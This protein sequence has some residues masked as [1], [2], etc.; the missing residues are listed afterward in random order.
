MNVRNGF[1]YRSLLAACTAIFVLV[2]GESAM[3]VKVGDITR[4]KGS[5]RN[6]LVGF[7]LVTG[8]GKN[9]DKEYGPTTRALAKL[10]ERFASPVAGLEELE[11]AGV[12]IVSLTARLPEFGVREGDTVDV[13]VTAVGSAKSLQG[14]RLLITP[15]VSPH[16][17]DAPPFGFAEGIVRC[18]DSQSP[19]VGVVKNGGVMEQDVIHSFI[20]SGRELPYKLS[21]I[22][23]TENYLTLLISDPQASAVLA[24]TIAMTVNGMTRNPSQRSAADDDPLS[25]RDDLAMA[26][27]PRTVLVRVP[28][29][30]MLNPMG[31]VDDLLQ[32][33]VVEEGTGEARVTLNRT[34]GTIVISGDVEISPVA[35][36][37]KGISIVPSANGTAAT[38]PA[39]PVVAL[40]PT[41]GKNTKLAEL[42]DNLNKLQVSTEVLIDIIEEIHKT[43]NLHGKLIRETD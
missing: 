27:D 11:K 15:M 25:I 22:K 35:V 8:L 19:T 23:P 14:G 43:G 36:S 21:W 24:N 7:G 38:K 18:P 1:R 6:T 42:V 30:E 31:F 3:A 2:D 9:G 16:R 29:F 5:R 41:L 12:A 39:G 34:K 17:L 33:P 10:H 28:R 37:V 26:V 32:M 4:L 13:E 40:D 20:A